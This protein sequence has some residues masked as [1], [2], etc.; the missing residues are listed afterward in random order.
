VNLVCSVV[1][2]S[3][4][5]EAAEGVQSET[6]GSQNV[7]YLVSSAGVTLWLTKAEIDRVCALRGPVLA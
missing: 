3:L 4:R 2:R 7:Q 5:P 6:T 1:Q